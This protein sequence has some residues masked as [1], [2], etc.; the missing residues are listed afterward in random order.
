M[1]AIL[2]GAPLGLTH[3]NPVGRAI[4]TA[5][6]PAPF[7]KGLQQRHP[8]AIARQ[9][10][11][12]NAPRHSAQNVAGQ[13][14]HAHPGQNQKTAVVGHPAQMS[15]ALDRRPANEVIPRPRLPSRR[16][17]QQTGPIPP[18][19]VPHQILDVLPD[20][21]GVAQIMILMQQPVKEGPGFGLPAQRLDWQRLQFTQTGNDRIGRVR[22]PPDLFVAHAV[23][24]KVAAHRQ[25][26]PPPL[27]Q[28]EQQ[29]A[30]RHVLDL[31]GEA[32]PVPDP[33]Q[34]AREPIPTL[35]GRGRQQSPH[36]LQLGRA[37][38]PAL[39][40]QTLFHALILHTPPGRAQPPMKLLL[41]AS[42]PPIPHHSCQLIG[43]S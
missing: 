40:D 21:A 23:G 32:A 4:T 7:H 17:Q 33:A 39:H 42:R 36:L 15:L 28:L 41:T 6:E 12:R 1:R 5:P 24:R 34:V 43:K 19:P 14:R 3:T 9:P 2:P 31:A 16:A 38:R 26:H 22:E 13:F 27:L 18:L 10:V 25:R 20:G 37:H 29:R 8:L 35:I 11:R 30:G